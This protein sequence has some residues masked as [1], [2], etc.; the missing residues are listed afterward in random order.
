MW[1][2]NFLV[3]FVSFCPKIESEHAGI[4]IISALMDSLGPN[5]M[6]KC[7]NLSLCVV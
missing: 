7:V 2:E 3:I 1:P 5:D 4:L 6:E